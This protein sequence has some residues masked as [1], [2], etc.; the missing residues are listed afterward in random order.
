MLTVARVRG[1]T[2]ARQHVVPLQQRHILAGGIARP[3]WNDPPPLVAAAAWRAACQRAGIEGL[4]LHDLTSEAASRL[5]EAAID[6]LT[7]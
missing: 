4:R 1:P 6:L 3:D 7:S 5:L 2:H